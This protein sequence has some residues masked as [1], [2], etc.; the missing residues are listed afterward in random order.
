MQKVKRAP[1]ADENDPAGQSWQDVIDEFLKVPG[2]HAQSDK[3][4]DAGLG[5]A[6]FSGQATQG[7]DGGMSAVL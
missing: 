4:A 3:N 6:V 1:T 5:E 7:C 2:T